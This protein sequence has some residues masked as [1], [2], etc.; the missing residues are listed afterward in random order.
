MSER[1]WRIQQGDLKAARAARHEFTRYLGTRMA[2]EAERADAALIF[3]ELVTNAVRFARSSV[4]FEVLFAPGAGG[5]G[6]L[7]VVD[8]AD[9]FDPAT[10]APQPPYAERGRGLYIAS[11]LARESRIASAEQR[12]EVMAV[13]P[14]R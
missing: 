7:R 3:G 12:C 1:L 13:L 4:G 9:C 14:I 5:W 8:D 10:I 11:Q 2:H 6:T